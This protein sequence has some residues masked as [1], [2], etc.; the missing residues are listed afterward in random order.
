MKIIKEKQWA[1]FCY[2]LSLCKSRDFCWKV[3]RFAFTPVQIE[4]KSGL[5]GEGNFKLLDH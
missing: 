2:Q 3:H 1:K 4:L 5:E